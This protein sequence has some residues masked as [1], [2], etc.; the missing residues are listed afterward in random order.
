M[1]DKAESEQRI[2]DLEDDVRVLTE[3]EKDGA[4][5]VER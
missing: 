2:T 1:T 3:R 5:E 4:M